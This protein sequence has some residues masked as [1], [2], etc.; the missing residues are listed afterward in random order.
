MKYVPNNSGVLI[1]QSRV[2][3]ATGYDIGQHDKQEIKNLGLSK[4]TTDKLLPFVL[5]KKQDAQ[6]VHKQA[7]STKITKEEADLIDF[8]S[9][10]ITLSSAIMN[11]NKRK[12]DGTPKFNDLTTEQQ[13]V[14]ISRTF[15]QGVDMPNKPISPKFYQAAL[16]NNWLD[17]EYHL[18][19]YNT[20]D[21]SY[22]TR[23]TLESN[24][25]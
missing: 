8:K 6:A 13:T 19:H 14:I 10:E 4:E 2:T 23:V 12:K 11:W 22:I 3:I 5:L 18:R 24:I 20:A 17:A 1:G 21:K 16:S 9:N 7:E 15:H 25:L